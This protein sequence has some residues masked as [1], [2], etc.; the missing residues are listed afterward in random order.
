[1]LCSACR[2]YASQQFVVMCNVIGC[3]NMQIYNIAGRTVR[4]T[5]YSSVYTSRLFMKLSAVWSAVSN[6]FNIVD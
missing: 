1:M 6:T 4:L 5:V 2:I 3:G